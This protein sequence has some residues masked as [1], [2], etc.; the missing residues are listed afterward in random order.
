MSVSVKCFGRLLNDSLDSEETAVWEAM[1]EYVAFGYEV[2]VNTKDRE[3]SAEYDIPCCMVEVG[4][5]I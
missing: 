4:N 5:G 2:R 1:P 3:V